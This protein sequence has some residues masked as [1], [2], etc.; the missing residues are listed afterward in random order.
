LKTD[1]QFLHNPIVRHI[2]HA[3]SGNVQT[4]FLL[5]KY[6]RSLVTTA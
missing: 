1:P 2:N 5:P 3:A 4:K 6:N